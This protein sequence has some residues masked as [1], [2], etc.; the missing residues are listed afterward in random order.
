MRTAQLLQGLEYHDAA[1]YSEPLYVDEHARV[2]RFT[3]KPRQNI[4]AHE[5]AHSPF[6]VVVLKGR[7]VFAGSDGK[8]HEL[9]PNSLLIFEPGERHTV[10]A[11]D[12]ELVFVGFLHGVA[13]AR[14]GRVG[15][16]LARKGESAENG[17]DRA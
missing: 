5:A 12:E 14:T 3:L 7:G 10:R 8:E 1:P 6:Y 13:G 16:T 4:P 11:L 2:L 17:V 9:G 15:G